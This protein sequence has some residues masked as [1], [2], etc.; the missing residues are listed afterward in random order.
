[1]R[2]ARTAALALALVATLPGC[3]AIIS[4]LPHV[5]AAVVDAVQVLDAIEAF[6]KRYFVENPD[7]PRELA[8]GKA[9]AK[10]RGSLNAALR[11]AQ[12]TEKL[13]QQKVDAA[14]ADFKVAYQELLALV[15]PLGVKP[16]GT[17]AAS[18]NGLT[19]PTPMA[20]KL[21]VQ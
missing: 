6:V 8:V 7:P 10:A 18:P 3:G 19:V 21:K 11:V 17:L 16:A 5:I 4:A 9:I 15:G 14:F 13:D 2:I 20:L 12:G 1:M